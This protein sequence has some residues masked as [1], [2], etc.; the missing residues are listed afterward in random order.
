M[1]FL[2][3]CIVRRRR[4]W[5]HWIGWLSGAISIGIVLL[6]IRAPTTRWRCICI[7]SF[8]IPIRFGRVCSCLIVVAWSNRWADSNWWTIEFSSALVE[9]IL[10]E[11]VIAGEAWC[12]VGNI[13]GHVSVVGEA[14]STVRIALA[15]WWITVGHTIRESW[16][17]IGAIA[18][19]ISAAV[20]VAVAIIAA[21][22]EITT[23]TTELTTIVAT[24]PTVSATI[25]VAVASTTAW[26][27]QIE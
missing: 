8:V 9:I 23:T 12:A 11:C 27:G 16:T 13:A 5:V 3:L 21:T 18:I 6:I 7:R 2:L 26:F 19:E 10:L 20:S 4:I 14:S 24:G 1:G 17:A 22:I 25:V 15:A